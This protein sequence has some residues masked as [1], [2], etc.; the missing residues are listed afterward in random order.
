MK[1]YTLLL[2]LCLALAGCTAARKGSGGASSNMG[3]KEVD[4]RLN[5]VESHINNN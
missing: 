3:P 5:L 1:K 2:V 4:L